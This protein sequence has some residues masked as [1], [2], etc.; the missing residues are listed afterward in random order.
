LPIGLLPARAQQRLDALPAI[1]RWRT[2]SC[3]LAERTLLVLFGQRPILFRQLRC[4]FGAIGIGDGAVPLLQCR[5]GSNGL[6]SP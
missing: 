3:S 4:R 2:A 5:H 6:P 1:S